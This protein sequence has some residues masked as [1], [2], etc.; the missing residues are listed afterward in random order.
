MKTDFKEIFYT[1]PG[2][3]NYRKNLISIIKNTPNN[4]IQLKK[5]C[6]KLEYGLNTYDTVK[7]A[8]AYKN[9]DKNMKDK[10]EYILENINFQYELNEMKEG[11]VE[12]LIERNKTKITNSL[13]KEII[14]IF[15]KE[16]EKDR[17]NFY[18]PVNSKLFSDYSQLELEYMIEQKILKKKYEN[19][20]S[21]TLETKYL[22]KFLERKWTEL[23]D[24]VFKEDEVGR[25]L[26]DEKYWDFELNTEKEEIW[27]Y[28]DHN[29][30]KG[31]YYLI[32]E[33]ENNYKENNEDNVELEE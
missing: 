12:Q 17:N 13:K 30:S 26:L 32:Y 10:I 23:E 1:F 14:K 16:F 20:S 18:I 27:H 31:V 9:A 19:S 25:E 22:D 24:I 8:E 3:E 15:E 5:I 29:H 7:I 33:Y 4:K 11:K 2:E 6:E 28:F 21:L